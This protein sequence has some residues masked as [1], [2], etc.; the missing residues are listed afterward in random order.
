MAHSQSGT[1]RNTLEHSGTRW[2]TPVG[3]RWLAVEA[4]WC[5]ASAKQWSLADLHDYGGVAHLGTQTRSARMR[6]RDCPLRFKPDDTIS[7]RR[8][9]ARNETQTRSATAKVSANLRM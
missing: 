6:H 7:Y 1:S 9:A 2:N 4:R 3:C 5:S 8:R